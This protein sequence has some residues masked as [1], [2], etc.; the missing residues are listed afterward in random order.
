[1]FHHEFFI[2][3]LRYTTIFV[4]YLVLV[5]II[6]ASQCLTIQ[7][8]AMWTKGEKIMIMLLRKVNTKRQQNCTISKKFLNVKLKPVPTTSKPS[9]LFYFKKVVS[10][11]EKSKFRLLQ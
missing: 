10:F 1:M 8:G 7:C 6:F 3:R 11:N 4:D 2:Q 5:V 9:L